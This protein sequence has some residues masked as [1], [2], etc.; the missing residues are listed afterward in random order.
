MYMLVTNKSVQH[1]H[2]YTQTHAHTF[3]PW[4]CA[5]WS[6]SK[7]AHF[8]SSVSQTWA[9]SQ[10]LTLK[11]KRI[12]EHPHLQKAYLSAMRPSMKPAAHKV[13]SLKLEFHLSKNIYNP[14]VISQHFTGCQ[15][16]KVSADC[17]KEYKSKMSQWKMSKSVI[18]HKKSKLTSTTQVSTRKSSG[19]R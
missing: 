18:L 15:T 13:V 11:R 5:H 17:Y 14:A 1:A 6:W 9:V 10:Q 7:S 3:C 8:S 2:T 4:P 19:F 16:I 12:E